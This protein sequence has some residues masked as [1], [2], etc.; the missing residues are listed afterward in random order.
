VCVSVI[1]AFCGN[2]LYQHLFAPVASPVNASL[3]WA[4]AYTMGMWL[5]AYTNRR[6]WFLRV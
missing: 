5:I 1:P 4:I 3:L 2:W 6:K